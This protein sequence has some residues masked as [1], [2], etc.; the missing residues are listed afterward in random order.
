MVVNAGRMI[1]AMAMVTSSVR[2]AQRGGF[3]SANSSVQHMASGLG[4]YLGGLI[5]KQTA[6]GRLIHYGTV[7]W[8][9]AAV[10]LASLWFASRVRIAEDYPS[11]AEPLS[12]AAAAEATADVGEPLM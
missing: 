1:A 10:T 12:L 8:I 2:P 7:G 11:P 4:A 9:A 3:M 6:D 5:I